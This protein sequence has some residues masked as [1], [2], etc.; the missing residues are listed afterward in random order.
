MERIVKWTMKP[1]G[2]LHQEVWKHWVFFL[3]P[4]KKTPRLCLSSGFN[5]FDHQQKRGESFLLVALH[6]GLQ[7]LGSPIRD[8]TRAPVVDS[9]SPNHWTTR[10]F[11]R[12][13]IF[14][15]LL[16]RQKFWCHKVHVLKPILK[17]YLS[18]NV[19]SF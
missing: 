11:S 7:D 4:C 13:F 2:V 9:W 1:F 14:K 6:S 17:L 8:W 3:L 19:F 18:E 16:S 10:E 12:I 15:G 5:Y